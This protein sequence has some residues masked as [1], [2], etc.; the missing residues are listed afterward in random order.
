MQL[1]FGNIT[2]HLL[3]L[4]V[5]AVIIATI[6]I[7]SRWSRELTERHY[8]VYL[9]FLVSAII[10]KIFSY[11]T[12]SGVIQRWFPIGF[13]LLMFYLAANRSRRHLAKYKASFLGLAAALYQ[14]MQQYEIIPF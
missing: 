8:R 12:G 6:Y 11:D 13:A 5:S 2:I 4:I 7:L 1:E 3:P 14:I 10:A 9:Y